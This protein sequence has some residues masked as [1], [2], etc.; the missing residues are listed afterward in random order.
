MSELDQLR[1]E[2]ELLKNQIRV[3]AATFLLFD[4]QTA[5][6]KTTIKLCSKN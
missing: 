1:N 4:D 2:A 5:N 6:S 3:S